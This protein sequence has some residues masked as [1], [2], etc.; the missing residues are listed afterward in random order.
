MCAFKVARKSENFAEAFA[1]LGEDLNLPDDIATLLEQYVFAVFTGKIK[2][3]SYA[4]YT[5]FKLG[6]CTADSL[7]PNF[8]SLHQHIPPR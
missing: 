6:K 7:P 8:D 2:S 5:M 3:I 1:T 4:R